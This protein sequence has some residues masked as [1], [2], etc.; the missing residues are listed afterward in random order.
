MKLF[1]ILL[2]ALLAAPVSAAEPEPE[3][4]PLLANADILELISDY[5]GT[6]GARLPVLEKRSEIRRCQ[7]AVPGRMHLIRSITVDKPNRTLH[8]YNAFGDLLLSYPVC[9]SMNMG[10]KHKADDNRTPEGTFDLYG[11]YNSTDWTYKDTGS[12]CYGPFFIYLHTPRFYGIGIHGTNAPNSVPGRSS[13]G[14]MRMH[15]ESVSR[16]RQFVQKDLL[17]TVKPD[18]V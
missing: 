4:A 8:L 3:P 16:L 11:I 17:V 10:Q 18:P 15:N 12:K 13:H 2:V 1:I 6:R 9:A 5:R 14:C 7:S